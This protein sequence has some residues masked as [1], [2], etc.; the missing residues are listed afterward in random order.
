MAL[1][2]GKA[3]GVQSGTTSHDCMKWLEAKMAAGG[4][5]P[6]TIVEQSQ[7]TLAVN[8]LLRGKGNFDMVLTDGTFADG[9]R[10]LRGDSVVVKHALPAFFGEGAPDFC[11]TQEYR[12]AVKAG[13]YDLQELTDRVIHRMAQA[14]DL[15]RIKQEAA[16]RFRQHVRQREQMQE[17]SAAEVKSQSRQ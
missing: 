3:V 14:G 9:W 13:E 6:F 12:I 17:I 11:L 15:E 10:D 4:R 16:E 5:A 8:M 7:S 1:L 2:A